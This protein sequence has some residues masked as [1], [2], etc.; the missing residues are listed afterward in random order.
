MLFRWIKA[1]E[2]LGSSTC[3]RNN[4]KNPHLRRRPPPPPTSGGFCLLLTA[5]HLSCW[6]LSSL[7]FWF[8]FAFFLDLFPLGSWLFA[9]HTIKALFFISLI[10]KLRQV[11]EDDICAKTPSPGVGSSLPLRCVPP[12]GCQDS[13]ARWAL[14][15]RKYRVSP[16]TLQQLCFRPQKESCGHHVA[17]L[18]NRR[19]ARV[20]CF[21]IGHLLKEVVM[22]AG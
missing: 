15:G 22:P 1:R 2:T 12:P 21:S 18:S 6:T 10:L 4:P 17:H 5:G 7:G 9:R 13:G 3:I 19:E 20:C 16:E 11:W 8:L 14:E